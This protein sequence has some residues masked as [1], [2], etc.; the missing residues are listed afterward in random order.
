MSERSVNLNKRLLA[1]ILSLIFIAV[2]FSGCD[3]TTLMSAERLMRPP[4]AYKVNK[5]LK[6]AF[7]AHAALENNLKGITL[8]PPSTG[9]YRSAFVLHDIDL[10]GQEE[11]LVFYAT[12]DGSSKGHIAIMDYVNE[13]WVPIEDFSIAGN[14]VNFVRFV[15]MNPNTCPAI[16][17]SH[18]IYESDTNKAISVYICDNTGSK[19]KVKHLCS[20]L[21]SAMENID[22]DSDGSLDIFLIQ[23]DFSDINRPQAYAY[24]FRMLDDMSLEKFGSAK[25]DGTISAYVGVKTEKASASSPMRIYVDAIKG[26]QQMITEV[27]YWNAV[28]KKLVTPM[29]DVETQ[30]NILTRRSDNLKSQDF[31]G[32]GIIEIPSQRPLDSSR[33]YLTND[34]F[35]QQMYITEWIEIENETEYTMTATLVNARD[36][37]IVYYDDMKKLIGEFTVYDLGNKSKWS[38]KQYDP[39]SK[40]TG[41]EIFSIAYIAK[42]NDKSKSINKDYYLREDDNFILYFIPTELSKQMGIT[43][44]DIKD[45]IK[46]FKE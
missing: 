22:I 33:R 43:T 46:T 37:Y 8:M 42:N 17:V 20:E 5:E 31:D 9:D 1:L 27:V 7:E 24:A 18:N 23:Q 41:E 45:C 32:D 30:S 28:S 2:S 21:Y 38:F 19:V 25:L 36:S 12:Q 10:D 11:A 34:N 29:F 39:K 15:Q 44:Q 26:E 40:E 14:T 35:F 3:G 6:D 13:R 16:I 4:L